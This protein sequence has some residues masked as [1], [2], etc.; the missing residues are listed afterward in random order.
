MGVGGVA[1]FLEADAKEEVIEVILNVTR[2]LSD[3]SMLL[4]KGLATGGE[5]LLK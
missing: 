4:V 5:G 2:Q 1:W 3:S